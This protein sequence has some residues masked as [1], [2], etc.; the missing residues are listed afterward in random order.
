MEEVGMCGTCGSGT[1]ADKR[2][3]TEFGGKTRR[4]KVTWKTYM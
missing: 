2:K 3:C 1:V 4:K